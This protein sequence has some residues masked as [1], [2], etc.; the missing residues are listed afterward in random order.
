[1]T[2]RDAD[3]DASNERSVPPPRNADEA[4]ERARR[5]ALAAV[6]EALLAAR[7]ALDAGA[8]ATL[9]TT[10]DTNEWLGAAAHWLDEAAAQAREGAGRPLAPWLDAV[11]DALDDEIERWE[12]RSRQDPE[13]R[14]VLRAFL[15]VREI[16]WEFGLRGQ[17]SEAPSTTSASE[18]P[19]ERPKPAAAG[20]A[21]VRPLRTPRRS[22]ARIERVPV[23]G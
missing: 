6:S 7:C 20:G 12:T 22:S 4:L 19:S 21:R 17:R 15:G 23:E 16:L 10:S 1:M 13:A 18:T 5:H 2:T 8:L 11:S 14:S 9:G 3:T